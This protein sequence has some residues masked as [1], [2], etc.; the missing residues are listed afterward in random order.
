VLDCIRLLQGD[1]TSNT[2]LKAIRLFEGEMDGSGTVKTAAAAG[3]APAAAALHQLQQW[4]DP[5]SYH[6]T[7]AKQQELP[8]QLRRQHCIAGFSAVQ[9]VT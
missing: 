7:F 4:W 3:I 9:I 2:R 1:F 5:A 8:L 6:W